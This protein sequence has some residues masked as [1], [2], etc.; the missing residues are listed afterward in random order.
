MSATQ[1]LRITTMNGFLPNSAA[2][3][4]YAAVRSFHISGSIGKSSTVMHSPYSA[5]RRIAAVAAW[6]PPQ[7]GQPPGW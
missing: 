1:P 4:A 7:I 6:P 2:C 3:S 5:E